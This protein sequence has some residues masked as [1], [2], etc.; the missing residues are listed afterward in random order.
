[1][2]RTLF[3]DSLDHT[4][5]KGELAVTFN[6]ACNQSASRLQTSH[7]S[8][9]CAP[10][11]PSVGCWYCYCSLDSSHS[12][13]DFL[14]KVI[15]FPL[16]WS[17]SVRCLLCEILPGLR[18]GSRRERRGLCGLCLL[19]ILLKFHSLVR[20]GKTRE[21]KTNNLPVLVYKQTCKIV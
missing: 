1:M 8:D 17:T 4:G 7:G 15:Y 19:G 16:F 18:S 9:V 20:E 21:P 6:P 13:R 5:D 11:P 2:K 14:R 3:S 12:E 10:P